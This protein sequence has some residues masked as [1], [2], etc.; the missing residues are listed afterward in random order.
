MPDENRYSRYQRDGG[1]YSRSRDAGGPRERAGSR[2][3]GYDPDI[4]SYRT[5]ANQ[6]DN[7]Y[8][9]RDTRYTGS[10]RYPSYSQERG[11]SGYRGAGDVQAYRSGRSTP[12]YGASG[13]SA[14]YGGYTGAGATRGAGGYGD[15]RGGYSRAGYGNPRSGYGTP[16]ADDRGGYGSPRGDSRGSYGASRSS[17]PYGD[18]RSSRRQ[19]SYGGYGDSAARSAYDGYGGGRGYRS[20]GSVQ[21]GATSGYGS[22]ERSQRTTYRMADDGYAAQ[23]REYT[24]GQPPR[25]AAPA[26]VDGGRGGFDPSSVVEA[27]QMAG[28]WVVGHARIVAVALVAVLVFVGIFQ[29]MPVNVQVDGQALALPR[30]T[31]YLQLVDQGYVDAQRGDLLDIEGQLLEEGAGGDP[32]FYVD[33]ERV[34]DANSG[35]SDAG[36][37]TAE[38]GEDTTENYTTTSEEIV[39]VETQVAVDHEA[40]A[41]GAEEGKFNFYNGVLH[42]VTDPGQEGISE[43]R[44]GEVSGK[45][46]DF[47]VQEMEPRIIENL[48]PVLSDKHKYL[49]L[50][51]DD[52]P[53]PNDT[54]TPGVLEVLDKYGVKGTFFMLGTEAEQYPEVAKKV[55][56]AGHQ[57]ASHSYSHAD[58]HFLNNTTE[59]DVRYQVGHA[60]EILEEATGV[61]VPY[62]RPPGGN[63]DL[64]A[65]KAAGDLADGYIG[66]SLDPTDYNLPGADAIAQTVID[67]ATPGDIILLHDGGG[68]RSQTIA[69]LDKLIP[70]LQ[71]EGYTFVTIDE[72]VE[73]ILEER[74]DSTA[75]SS[76]ATDSDEDA[77]E[78]V[79]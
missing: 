73:A 65:I 24:A 22:R 29:A 20:S 54:E 40:E 59:D 14:G 55:A 45:T 18:Y 36:N 32:I 16:R 4:R 19:A 23:R 39:P 25:A 61:E 71:D 1:G 8:R 10:S 6:P 11:A 67:R 49:A 46:A 15:S 72:L 66:W 64:K 69:A 75:T 50:T 43:T 13:G 60:R 21:P 42:V 56:D 30:S 38:R 5:S 9:S 33:G 17:D 7:G 77:D 53:S 12:G 62:I 26:Y 58:E 70:A 27:L 68:D 37:I 78:A 79:E 48:H 76:A 74:G 3:A 52:G 34:A 44:T 51:F 2:N 28:A 41:L 35:I 63:V 31:T 47:V 57:V